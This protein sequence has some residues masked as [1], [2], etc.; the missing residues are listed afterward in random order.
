[1]PPRA[2]RP[3]N[4]VAFGG[5]TGLST[6]LRGLASIAPRVSVTAVVAVSDDGG[7][8]G[9]LRQALDVPAVG[10]LRACLAAV[11]A[12]SEWAQM[13]EYRFQREGTLRGHALGNL[14]LAA[15]HEREGNLSR[16][17]AVVERLVGARAR[18]LPATNARPVLVT[19]M[20]DGRLIHGES[21]SAATRGP[22]DRVSLAPE[23]V[24]PAPGVIEAVQAADMIVFGP[25][26]LFT[27]VI[28]S[29]LAAGVPAAIGRSRATKVLVQ[30]LTSQRGETDTMSIVDHA[31]AVRRHLGSASLDVVLT[32]RW[33]GVPPLQGLVPVRRSLEAAG[34]LEIQAGLTR[35]GAT[36]DP[37]RLALALCA[38][39]SE[40]VAKAHH[41]DT[42]HA[43]PASRTA[44]ARH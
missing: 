33:R 42:R 34:L 7:S 25:G 17:V 29:A 13:L 14:L 41:A 30:N 9:R 31:T 43:Q 37:R 18:I 10:D 16:A 8:S 6:L 4:V 15:L 20:A 38:I 3:L 12:Q 27:S 24:L 22:I 39:A 19:R 23:V 1:M 36:H 2:R 32:H 21:A 35:D 11:S 26:S 5:G 28:A 40:R 44:S